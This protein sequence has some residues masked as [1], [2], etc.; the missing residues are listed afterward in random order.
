MALE[1]SILKSTKK[2]LGL[3]AD[4]TAF[5]EEVTSFIN[6]SFFSLKR[7]GI[8][9]ANGFEIE[10]D[11][12]VWDDFVDVDMLDVSAMNALRTYIYLKVRLLFDPPGTPYHIQAIEDQ[13]A[14]L[15]HTLLTE[16]ELIKWTPP[17]SSLPSLP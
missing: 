13:I 11:E 4:Y 16:R 15:E 2:K 14:E 12:E 1:Q 10:G 3:D 9:P 5:D 17:Q 8:G 7:I 6:S